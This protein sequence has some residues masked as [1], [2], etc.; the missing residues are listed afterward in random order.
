MH[1]CAP[2]KRPGMERLR[3]MHMPTHC[4]SLWPPNT[5]RRIP[6]HP[7]PTPPSLN[8]PPPLT[9]PMVHHFAGSTRLLLLH[10]T[11][12]ARLGVISGRSDTRR[13]PLSW[14]WLEGLAVVHSKRYC[15]RRIAIV[16]TVVVVAVTAETC[17]SFV[18]ACCERMLLVLPTAL[19]Q[20]YAC[21]CLCCH[22]HTFVF[23][24]LILRKK[25]L[26]RLL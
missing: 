1:N 10:N 6:P 3:P 14:W 17:E 13:P 4:R 18:Y 19:L 2:A 12:R 20:Q 8:T 21:H 23:P 25:Q 5:Q 9:C 26:C 7:T 24:L 15:K 22:G 11:R 16:V